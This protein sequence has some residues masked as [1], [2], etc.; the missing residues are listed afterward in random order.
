MAVALCRDEMDLEIEAFG[1]LV[2]LT[3]SAPRRAT[4]KW[5]Q[6]SVKP[7]QTPTEIAAG[8]EDSGRALL[9]KTGLEPGRGLQSGPAFSTGL[10][11][12]H[13]VAH[14]TTKPGHKDV[15]PRHRDVMKVDFGVRVNGWIVDG[16]FTM[17]FDPT[18][19]KLLAER[20]KTYPVKPTVPSARNSD[21]TKMD[22]G[23]V[24]AIETFGSPGRGFI[25]D[26]ASLARAMSSPRSASLSPPELGD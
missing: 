8:V 9:D 19:D 11:L 24:F 23:D 25:R 5:V 13:C 4:R 1:E 3:A 14:H 17:S 26:G 16:A 20:G 2:H 12:N 18:Y 21:Q 22:E 7:G 10:S 15:V 6:E